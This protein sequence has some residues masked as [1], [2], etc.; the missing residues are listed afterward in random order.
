MSE[1]KIVVVKIGTNS[2]TTESGRLDLNNLRDIVNQISKT[3][4]EHNI[5]FVVVTSG[6]VTSGAEHIGFSPKS[7]PEKQAAASV[8]QILL[9]QEYAYFFE[10]LGFK[11]GQILLTKDNFTDPNR[12][13]NIKNTMAE[14]ISRNII[15]II[16]E[17]DSI[18]TEEIQFGDNDALSADVAILVNADMLILLTDTE[19]VFDDNPKLNKSAKLIEQI[20]EISEDLLN[21]TG[22]TLSPTSKGG[23]KSKLTAAKRCREH[24][25]RVVI[26]GGRE[27]NV[28]SNIVNGQKVGTQIGNWEGLNSR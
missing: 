15:P 18:S 20:S 17:N 13:A 9:M 8:G 2:L 10:T 26:A 24:G 7:L 3:A 6:A 16:N 4:T 14:L 25:I 11:T 27:A 5:N 23:M 22:G 21:Q 28:I 19:G 1:K 12:K